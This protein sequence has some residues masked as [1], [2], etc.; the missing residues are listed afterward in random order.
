VPARGLLKVLGLAFGIALAVGTV[1]G[2]GILRTPG[3]VA[4]LLTTPALFFGAWIGGA[5]YAL[6]GATAYAEHAAMDPGAGGVYPWARRAFGDYPAFLVGYNS[7]LQQCAIMAGLALLV[8]EY[9]G[10]VVPGLAGRSLGVASIL[11]LGFLAAHRQGIR[12][13]SG[14]QQVA[15]LLKGIALLLLVGACFL[16]PAAAPAAASAPAATPVLVAIVLAMQGVIFTFDGYYYPIY[17]G[18]EFRNPG[19]D[20]P[21]AIFLSLAGV[22]ALYLLLNLA[23]VRLLSL[24]AMAGDPLVAATAAHRLLGASGDTALR[25]LMIFSLVG[26]MNSTFLGST[27]IA[28]SLSRDRLFPVRAVAVNAGGTPTAALGLSTCVGFLFLLSG[29]FGAVIATLSVFTVLNYLVCFLALYRLRATEPDRPRPYLAWG[30]PWTTALAVA[31]SIVF[32]VGVVVSDPRHALVAL[33][34]LALSGPAFLL[35]KR[36]VQP[37]ALP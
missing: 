4:A 12:T 26:T 10:A 36:A 32:L 37:A 27:R 15:T 14:I 11:L 29:T 35:L 19:R 21:R 22:V 3:T 6:L 28:Y 7:W 23:F 17:C 25:W 30:Y 18:E 34:A 20:I 31:I 1:V 24:R 5:V 8:A 9:A 2:G 33:G 13:G 16:V